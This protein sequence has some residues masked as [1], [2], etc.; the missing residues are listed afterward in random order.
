MTISNPVDPRSKNLYTIGG[1]AALLA[2]FVFRRNLGAELSLLA[3][4]GIIDGI[5]PDCSEAISIG[6][7]GNLT[8]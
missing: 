5:L 4:F 2:V 6:E 8:R 7:K 3:N 1:I